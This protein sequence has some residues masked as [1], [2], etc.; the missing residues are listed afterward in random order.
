M[1]QNLYFTWHMTVVRWQIL[2][3]MAEVL[4]KWEVHLKLSN[5]GWERIKCVPDFK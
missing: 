2:K 3:S 1:G 4:Q 5:G